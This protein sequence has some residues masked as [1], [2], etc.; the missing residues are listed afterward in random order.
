MNQARVAVAIVAAAAQPKA[1]PTNYPS[2]FAARVAGRE[3]RPLGDLFGLT[4]FGVNLTRLAPGA[5]SA[6]RHAHT[7]QDE[8]IYIL[9]GHPTL[10]TDAGQTPLAPGMCAGFKGGTGDGHHLVNET[11]IDVL[12]LEIGDRSPGD[13]ASYP[14]DDIRAVME[15][16]KWVFAHK[17]GRP[18]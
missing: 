1:K 15:S 4:N 7:V 18:Y 17:D 2:P 16:G 3:K 14:D 6:L 11:D 10:R 13:S 12:Y 9:Q 8:F 5:I